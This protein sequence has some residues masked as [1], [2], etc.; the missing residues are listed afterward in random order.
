MPR[1]RR[2]QY[3]PRSFSRSTLLSLGF[4]HYQDG[5]GTKPQNQLEDERGGIVGSTLLTP[6]FVRKYPNMI[7]DKGFKLKTD[8]VKVWLEK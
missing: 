1:S 8:D 4:L 7:N 6:A 3:Q 2:S 5:A